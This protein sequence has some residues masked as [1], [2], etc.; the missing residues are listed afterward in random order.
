[1][2]VVDE[3]HERALGREVERE[4]E[5]P[6]QHGRRGVLGRPGARPP[7]AAK[8][9]RRAPRRRAAARRGACGVGELALEQLAHH[10]ERQ[11]AFELAR[12]GADDERPT[13][14]AAGAALRAAGSCPRPPPPR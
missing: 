11:V 13:L 2:Q 9:A 8:T 4:P 7:D 14:G 3:E 5:Q 6:V 12:A 10:V 1:V